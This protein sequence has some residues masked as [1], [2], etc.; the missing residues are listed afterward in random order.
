MGGKWRV[1]VVKS[2]VGEHL[3]DQLL[4]PMALA[5][6]GS[7]STGP[8]SA[9]TTTNIEV[10]RKFLDVKFEVDRVAVELSAQLFEE[11][12]GGPHVVAVV[13]DVVVRDHA[14]PLGHTLAVGD[15]VQLASRSQARRALLAK[16]YLQPSTVLLRR[17]T[18]EELGGFDRRLARVEDWDLLGDVS[19][20]T[21]ATARGQRA[22]RRRSSR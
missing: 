6:G 21:K 16:P 3:A 4:I 15:P 19:I 5:R 20:R 13:A 9:H 10:I 7:F 18:F 11:L 17:S 2:P 14:V 22:G 8:L 1:E 12:R